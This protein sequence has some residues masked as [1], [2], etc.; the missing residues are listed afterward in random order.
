MDKYVNLVKT[1]PRI[2]VVRRYKENLVICL[3]SDCLFNRTNYRK[4][5]GKMTVNDEAE[6][7]WKDVVEIFFED[8]SIILKRLRKTTYNLSAK[9]VTG[10]VFAA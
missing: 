3:P 1:T 7:M 6:R 9:A 10:S 8:F 5:G 4:P 2:P